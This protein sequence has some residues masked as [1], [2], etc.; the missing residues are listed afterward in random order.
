VRVQGPHSPEWPRAL[1]QA[2]RQLLE[3]APVRA[4]ELEPDCQPWK[5]SKREFGQ[6]KPVQR[7]QAQARVQR[8]PGWLQWWARRSLELVELAAQPPL[9]RRPIACEFL[10]WPVRERSHCSRGSLHSRASG[11]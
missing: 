5:E 10:H 1:A 4:R 11:R 9:Q 6:A 8:Q 7:A 2:R 3:Q